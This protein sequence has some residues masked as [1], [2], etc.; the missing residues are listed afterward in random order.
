MRLARCW[1]CQE[2]GVINEK[3]SCLR[4]TATPEDRIQLNAQLEAVQME[5]DALEKQR[6]S[7]SVETI[8]KYKELTP[9]FQL[10]R[11]NGL[12]FYSASSKELVSLLNQYIQGSIN[13]ERFIE[14]YD[15]MIQIIQ[16]ESLTWNLTENGAWKQ[17][18]KTYDC[19][20]IVLVLS[21]APEL[22][23]R[24]SI[25]LTHKTIFAPLNYL[26][27]CNP[28]RF[29]GDQRYVSLWLNPL[30]YAFLNRKALATASGLM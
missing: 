28:Q 5:L 4:T 26:Y 27:C 1:L 18:I 3:E 17:K 21:A 13:M 25:I 20:S 10:V 9:L 19:L 2:G 23:Y 16:L 30:W 12:N 15:Q 14:K 22:H 7:I 29:F 24:K 8:A 6:Y 11:H